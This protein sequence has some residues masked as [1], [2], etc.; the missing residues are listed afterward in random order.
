[1]Y[2]TSEFEAWWEAL[3]FRRVGSQ[4]RGEARGKPDDGEGRGG[5]AW[6]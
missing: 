1:M 3:G 5:G 4:A 6:E 2:G